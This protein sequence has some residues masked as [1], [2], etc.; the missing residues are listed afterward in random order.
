[1]SERLYRVVFDLQERI[2]CSTGIGVERLW[3]EKSGRLEMRVLNVPFYVRGIAFGDVVRVRPDHERR[4]FVFEELLA[5]SGNST[6]RIIL[7]GAQPEG[8]V[9]AM[10]RAADCG[11]EVGPQGIFLWAIDVPA[12]VNYASVRADLL[13]MADAGTINLEEGAI[14]GLHREGFG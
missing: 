3:A 2:A 9:G 7:R 11:W 4:E 13:K 8:E 6:M 12:H 1:M 14:S 10:L 5:E